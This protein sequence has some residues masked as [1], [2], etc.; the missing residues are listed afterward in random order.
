M[1]ES[2]C[3]VS[4]IPGTISTC[5]LSGSRGKPVDWLTVAALSA[6]PVPPRQDFWACTDPQC[7]VVYFAEDGSF[8]RVHDLRVFPGFKAGGNERLVCYCFN[9]RRRDIENELLQ[10][11]RTT[12]SERIAADVKASNCACEVRNPL[13]R[14]CLGEVKKAEREIH[15][16]L[17]RSVSENPHD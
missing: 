12:I 5:P 8:L 13:G 10:S 6:K 15:L 1:S 4:K 2:C 16:E 7:D 11:G 14:C 3:S 9:Y 17:Q